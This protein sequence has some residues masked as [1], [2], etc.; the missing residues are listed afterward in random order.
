MVYKLPACPR[1][2]D[3]AHRTV[4]A[5]CCCDALYE[6]YITEWFA[7]P[8]YVPVQLYTVLATSI[9]FCRTQY[10]CTTICTAVRVRLPVR[11]RHSA[12]QPCM[13][14]TAAN[15]Q[16]TAERRSRRRSRPGRC[17]R[18]G[19]RNTVAIWA[20]PPAGAGPFRRSGRGVVDR[21]VTL[22][23]GWHVPI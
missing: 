8:T 7:L 9:H 1:M 19:L 20:A 18:T 16:T 15:E 12:V 14:G 13:Y 21:G 11:T 6:S 5:S 3:G 2:S 23:E 17:Q 22:C 10:S 4:P